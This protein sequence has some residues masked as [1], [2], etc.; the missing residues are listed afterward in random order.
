MARRFNQYSEYAAGVTRLLSNDEIESLI[1]IEDCLEILERAYLEL[2]AGEATTRQRTDSL[3]A[4]QDGSTFSLKTVDGVLPS[5]G[6]GA[7][8]INADV[9]NWPMSTE[10]ARREK[11]PLAAGRWV[12]LVLLFSSTTGE[13][14][15]IFPDGVL[16]RMRVAATSMIALHRLARRD[17]STL[18][19]IGSGW[20]AGAQLPAVLSV[21]TFEQ[22]R[23]FSPNRERR[24]Q[25]AK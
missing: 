13:P 17:V 23:C 12:G 18:A 1:S 19:L 11:L 25:F 16:Q 3:T 6:V 21:R 4:N 15:A 7:V 24:E 5:A 22:I 20:Q 10:G 8:R 9:L 14:L 2:D